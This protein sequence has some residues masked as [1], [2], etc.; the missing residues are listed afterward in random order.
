MRTLFLLTALALSAPAY[1]QAVAKPKAPP[2]PANDDQPALDT[3]AKMKA[4]ANSGGLGTTVITGEGESP[5]GLY[6]TPWRESRPEKDIDRP[7]RLLQEDMRP[8]DKDVFERQ[9]EYY[10]ALSGAAKRKTATP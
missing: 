3:G 6:L 5:L 1:A 10:D 8:I 4:P 2:A 7:A 9:V